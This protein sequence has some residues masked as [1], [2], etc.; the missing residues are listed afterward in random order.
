MM[1]TE[2]PPKDP[3]Y[4]LIDMPYLSESEICKNLYDSFYT[5][6]KASQHYDPDILIDTSIKNASYNLAAP[7]A[8]HIEA[9]G[10]GG[11]GTGGG[12]DPALFIRKSGDSMIGRFSSLYGFSA[13]EDGKILLQTKKVIEG[14]AVIDSY[15]SIEGKLHI[16]SNNLIIDNKLLFNHYND[17]TGK[18]TLD[19][20]GGDIVNFKVSNVS[21]E[22]SLSANDLFVSTGSLTYKNNA[23]YHAGN[24]NKED[25]DWTMFNSNVKGSLIAEGN[26]KFGALLTALNGVE[27][28]SDKAMVVNISGGAMTMT[29][30]IKMAKNVSIMYNDKNV[31]G[32]PQAGYIQISSSGLSLIL[33]SEYT[34]DIRLT[35]PLTSYQGDHTLIDMYGNASF[36]MSF[37]AGQGGDILLSTNQEAIVIHKKL[38]FSSNDGPAIYKD[39]FGIMFEATYENNEYRRP[40]YTSINIDRSTSMDAIPGK[41][42]ESVFVSTSTDFFMF[43]K[44]IEAFDFVGIQQST[45]RLYDNTL[46]FTEESKLLNVTDGIKH[47]GHSYFKDNLSS[48]RFSTGFAGE[49][50]AIRKKLDNGNIELTVDEAVVRKK[51]RIYELEI[52]K[53]RAVNGSLWVS[54]ACDG[55]KVTIIN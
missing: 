49:G 1:T 41:N 16:N 40:H 42:S 37:E 36:P 43:N 2:E 52:Q 14:Q 21:V 22:G 39:Q 26:S 5:S 51:M 34:Q 32:S 38:K 18:E 54:D 31:I 20:N 24:S 3:N 55:D 50:W 47:F 13:G 17:Q 48:E 6:I 35:S 12:V 19:I 8:R 23:I 33:G 53:I 4:G 27:L 10:G 44:P 45:T 29:G 9:G 7:I 25:V 15:L 46:F 28:G 11:G 30:N